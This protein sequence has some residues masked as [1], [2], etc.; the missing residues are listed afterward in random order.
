MREQY[1]DSGRKFSRERGWAGL[2][3]ELDENAD[4]SLCY[5]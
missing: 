5:T 2:E 4:A 1:L 3:M